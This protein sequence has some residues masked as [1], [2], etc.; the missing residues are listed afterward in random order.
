MAGQ[1]TKT[2]LLVTLGNEK[3]PGIA[4]ADVLAIV[5]LESRPSQNQIKKQLAGN[6]QTNPFIII[7]GSLNDKE[8]CNIFSI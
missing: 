5:E 3:P 2:L 1:K 4:T 6:R 7:K 8:C